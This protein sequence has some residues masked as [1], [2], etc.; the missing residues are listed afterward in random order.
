MMI[1]GKQMA[2]GVELDTREVGDGSYGASDAGHH[3]RSIRLKSHDYSRAGA[4]FITICTQDRACLFGEIANGEMRLNDAGRMV[5]E[6][7]IKTAE[8]RIEIE[9][10]EYV[11]MPN[12]FH[13]I[14]WISDGGRGTARRAPTVE[15]FGKPVAGSIPTIIRSFKSAVTKRINESRNTPGMLVWQRNYYEHIIRNDESLNHIRQYIADNPA[16]WET[17]NENPNMANAGAGAD[18]C[19]NADAGVGARRAVPLRDAAVCNK[20]EVP[21]HGG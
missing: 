2:S 14:L 7:W 10:G 17:D 15:R 19:A 18:A 5:V 9:S 3:R 11:A 20:S 1:E 16:N 4:Y 13:A 6:E 21:G 8:I 12:H